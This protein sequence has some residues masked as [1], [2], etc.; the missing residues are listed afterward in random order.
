MD[1]NKNELIEKRRKKRRRKKTVIILVL[2]FAILITLSLKLPYFKITK[3]NVVNNNTVSANEI[4]KKSGMYKGQNIFYL[5]EPKIKDNIMDDPY[6]VNV[7]IERVMP[8]TVNIVVDER[9]AVFYA[10]KDNKYA[11]IDKDG[12]VLE[13]RNDIANRNLIKLDGV[14][15]SKA[16]IGKTLPGI[17]NDKIKTISD[18]TDILVNNKSA[19]ESI[20]EIDITNN[21]DIVAYYNSMQ[22]KIGTND[23]MVKKLN[24]AVNI[25]NDEKLTGAKGY[26]DVSFNGNPVYSIDK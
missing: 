14:N 4:L 19:C 12:I 10:Q 7:K 6:I 24:K 1:N 3:I 8:S 21:V 20:K 16:Q 15:I 23:D 25:I 17:S 5:N 2:L 22:I 18:F 26:V 13:I 9:N 11:I